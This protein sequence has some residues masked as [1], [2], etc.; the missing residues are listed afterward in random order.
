MTE[1]KCLLILGM[2][3]S[4]TSAVSGVIQR[5]GFDFGS[6]TE[7]PSWDNPKGY[8]ENY[9]IQELNEEI[10][11]SIN[12]TWDQPGFITGEMLNSVSEGFIDKAKRIVSKEFRNA[13]IAIKDPRICLLLTFWIRVMKELGY[14]ISTVLVLRSPHEIAASLEKR[15]FFSNEKSY[16]LTSS[17]LLSADAESRELDR[18]VISYDDLLDRPKSSVYHLAEG[19][20]IS[21]EIIEN[22]LN[23]I[24][25]FIAPRL[26]NHRSGDHDEQR[27]LPEPFVAQKVYDAIISISKGDNVETNR[28]LLDRYKMEFQRLDQDKLIELSG[29]QAHFAK[30]IVDYGRGLKESNSES[31]R[32]NLGKEKLIF[33]PD[34]G[35]EVEQ[36]V[37]FPSNASCKIRIHKVDVE[38]ADLPSTYVLSDNAGMAEGEMLTFYEEFPQIIIKFHKPV[39]IRSLTVQVEYLAFDVKKSGERG[40]ARIEGNEGWQAALLTL[41]RHPFQFLKSINIDNF[42]TLQRA[43]KRE[44]PRQI[45]RNFIKLLKRSDRQKEIIQRSSSNKESLT[46]S[47][48]GT[49]VPEK[50]SWKTNNSARPSITRTHILYVTPTV[51]EYD[52]SSGGRRATEILKLIAQ[53]HSVSIFSLRRPEAKYKEH[54]ESHGIIVRSEKS[55]I[56]RDQVFVDV[57]ICSFYYTL[58]EIK[59]LLD[60]YPSARVIVDSVDVHWVREKRSIDTN[61][62]YTLDKVEKNKSTEVRAYKQADVVWAV[63]EEDGAAI[64]KEIPTAHVSIVSNVHPFSVLSFNVPQTKNLLFIGGY[65]HHPNISAVIRLARD[66]FPI[67]KKSILDAQLLIVGSN[68]PEEVIE[69]DDI[70]GVKFIGWVEE[71]ALK[72]LYDQTIASVV[73]LLSGAGV[74]GKITEA[75][76]YM[77]PVITNEI[78]NEGINLVHGESGLLA[79]TDEEFAKAIIDVLE[80][81]VDLESLAIKAQKVISGLVTPTDVMSNIKTSFYRPVSICI[82]T[83][84][85]LS[86]LKAC[87]KSILEHTEHP[88]FDVLVYS[89]GC[90][91]GTQKYL[92][93]QALINPL[94]KPIYAAT[95]EVFVRP[96]NH[97]M[98]LDEGRDVVLVN[99]DVEVTPGWL[100]GLCITA[101]RRSDIGVVGS[102]LLYPDGRLQEFGSELY[103]DGTGMNIGKNE[104]EPYRA[105]FMRPRAA[106]YVSGCSMYIKRSTIEQIGTFD[107]QFHPCYCEDSDYCYTA[108]EQGIATVVCP[109]SVVI[110][111]EGS[112]SGV[113]SDKGFKRFQ[114]INMK[115]FLLKHK[116]SLRATRKAINDFNKSLKTNPIDND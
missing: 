93:E 36:L 4:G 34:E 114:A 1:R 48:A 95:N 92:K 88:N 5:L 18:V 91:D 56:K 79:E 67:V 23:D 68:A 15:N 28:A 94:V 21:N 9:K 25:S 27:T 90:A 104:R 6:S 102:K 75:I 85:N 19:L 30:L 96:N 46:L 29:V 41:M 40:N 99:N 24:D 61:P 83:Y 16:L 33:N 47:E 86:L 109:K 74:K 10:L 115:K 77:T 20:S 59:S 51:P 105:E 2:H 44:S 66:I 8:Y 97:M 57:I 31:Q 45:I 101:Y 60:L 65:T 50:P 17:Y 63:S 54:F 116:A 106:A 84:N 89:N 22:G 73:P 43:L 76:S 38:F 113:D 42:R 53:N 87:L 37:F 82:V 13:Q 80:S 100:L 3:R 71:H 78:G 98:R 35:K 32:I 58:M 70:G 64:L 14:A 81:N 103:E 11:S 107:D 55:Q 72:S 69:L 49:A 108:W 7:D 110:H 62:Y 39:E 112:T 52:T 111:K 12:R 26:R